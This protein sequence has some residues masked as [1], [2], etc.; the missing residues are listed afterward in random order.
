MK[1]IYLNWGTLSKTW[2]QVMDKVQ[3][4]ERQYEVNPTLSLF[5]T[6]G[7]VWK[8]QCEVA[9][10]FKA[11]PQDL[12]F[13]HNV[14]VAMNDFIMGVDLPDG[15]LAMTDLEYGAVANI[16]KLRAEREQRRIHIVK[17]PIGSELTSSDQL[18]ELIEKQVPSSVRLL[19]ISHVMTGSGLKVPIQKLAK[20]TRKRGILLAVDGAHGP[21]ATDLDFSQLEDLDFYGGNL[22]KWMRGPKG[23]GFGWAP[24]RNHNKIKPLMAC[25]TSFE[26]PE[27]FAG[28]HGQEQWCSTML[29]SYCLNWSTFFALSDLIQIWNNKGHDLLETL[30]TKRNFVESQA[31]EILGFK[32]L[33]PAIHELQSPL[34]TFELPTSHVQ[35]NYQIIGELYEQK[36]VTV[37]ITPLKDTFALRFSV[38]TEVS[39]EDIVE[40]I[41]R[42]RDYFF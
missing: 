30:K 26:A 2:P 17:L 41:T 37:S 21:G 24:K 22:H 33:S 20:I 7:R 10:F 32:L 38:H 13:R 28:F 14:T 23:T 27:R 35:K 39:D 8:V 4:Y 12:F 29:M 5:E 1:E 42:V 9:H 25:W 34:V 6:W 19:L 3:D 31:K 15:D 40:G 18:L 36:G 11:R 16:L